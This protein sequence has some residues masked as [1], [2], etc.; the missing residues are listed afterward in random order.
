MFGIKSKKQK[1]KYKLIDHKQLVSDLGV[2]KQQLVQETLFQERRRL[3]LAL[4]SP[5]QKEKL[6]QIISERRKH[7]TNK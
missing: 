2:N 4:L 1:E 6:N 3:F 5:R 7:A